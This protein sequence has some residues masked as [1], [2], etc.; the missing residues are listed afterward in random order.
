[1]NSPFYVMAHG[2]GCTL[3]SDAAPLLSH[4]FDTPEHGRPQCACPHGGGIGPIILGTCFLTSPRFLCSGLG[5]PCMVLG[6]L[7]SDGS[8]LVGILLTIA[9]ESPG[10][11]ELGTGTEAV[12]QICSFLSVR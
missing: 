12:R 4:T 11:F 6:S 1:M 8:S 10:N 3:P 9:L 7:I 2:A 5:T